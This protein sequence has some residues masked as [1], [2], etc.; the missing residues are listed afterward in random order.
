LIT[1]PK[2]SKPFSASEEVG[3]PVPERFQYPDDAHRRPVTLLSIVIPLF[4]EQDNVAPLV[5]RI[6]Q[7]M[8]RLAIGYELILINDGSSDH[9]SRS[10]HDVARKDERIKGVHLRRN[11]GQT[12]ALVA[13]F[14]H[15]TGDVIVTLD[16][17][18]QND[19]DDIGILLKKLNEGY[20]IVSGWREDRQ[21]HALR[22]NI[23]SVLANKLISRCTGIKLHDFGCSLKV[24]RRSIVRHIHLYGEMHRFV[25]IYAVLSGA[26]LAEVPVRHH[27]RLHGNSKYGFE[28]VFKVLFDLIVV[29][30]LQRYSQKPMYLFGT[31]GAIS[32]LGSFAAAGGA[33]YYK[34]F[35]G[36][37]L[38][39]TPLPL[40]SGFLFLTA[41]LCILLGLLAELS[42][43]TYHES[44]DKPTY[45]IAET[46]NIKARSDAI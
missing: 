43:R 34:F 23:P 4:N 12:A 24:Y 38:I 17:D 37:T 13:G 31:C 35:G 14:H 32:L 21:D 1:L 36:K 2:R 11:Y 28:R 40:A 42:I 45:L 26:R 3:S 9:T 33:F 20:D 25:P 19:P 41:V 6:T 46:D 15:S 22:R 5:E 8:E 30:F 16:G 29:M 10:I 18:L 27:A 39:E 7:A 44:Q